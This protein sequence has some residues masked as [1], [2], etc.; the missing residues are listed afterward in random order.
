LVEVLSA[1][2]K[3][4]NEAGGRLYLSGVNDQAYDLLNGSEKLRLST[5]VTV[6]EATPILGESTEQAY[7][8]GNA[9]LV[10]PG[11]D[12]HPIRGS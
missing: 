2:A 6:V 1:Y 4:L 9:W 12:S 10:E 8:R 7:A 3:T 11:D 5:P